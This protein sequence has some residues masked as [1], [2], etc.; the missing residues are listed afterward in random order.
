MFSF[1]NEKRQTEWLVYFHKV[2]QLMSDN[3]ASLLTPN[4]GQLK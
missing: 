4:P 2:T 3:I 1:T